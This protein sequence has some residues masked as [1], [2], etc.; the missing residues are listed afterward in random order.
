MVSASTLFSAMV[1]GD[2][3][4][5]RDQC[6]FGLWHFALDWVDLC[7]WCPDLQALHVIRIERDEDEIQR[8]EDDMVAFDKLV[9]E[10][11]AKLRAKLAPASDPAISNPP[12]IGSEGPSTTT[13]PAAPAPKPTTVAELAPTF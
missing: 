5:Y 4:E 2:I 11:E 7:L 12:W 6:M 3:S 13:A 9:S 1:D 8:L 10:Y